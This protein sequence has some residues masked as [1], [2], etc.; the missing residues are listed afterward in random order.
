GLELL[1]GRAAMICSR[2]E[3]VVAWGSISI[4]RRRAGSPIKRA[5]SAVCS[6]DCGSGGSW[7]NRGEI[8]Q[9][10]AQRILVRAWVLRELESR[11]IVRAFSIGDFEMSRRLRTVCFEAIERLGRIV[12]FGMRGYSMAGMMATSASR[13]R[14]ASAQKEGTVKERSYLFFRG[15]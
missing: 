10:L 7:M 3:P 5:A 12:R 13:L 1:A 15:P 11:A 14:R 8:S 9:C 2:C 6:M 4:L